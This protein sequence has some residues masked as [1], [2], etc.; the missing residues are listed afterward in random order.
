MFE[1]IYP[2]IALAYGTFGIIFGVAL[3]WKTQKRIDRTKTAIEVQVANAVTDIKAQVTESLDFDVPEFDMTPLMARLD[4]LET[5]LPDMVGTH[6][7]MA[8]KGIQATEGKQIAAYVESLGIEGI[9]EEQ[10]AMAVERLTLKQKAA[11]E[12][13]TMKIPKKTRQDHPLSTQLFEH[14]RGTI[15]QYIIESDEMSGG[16]VH[17]EGGP[18]RSGTFRPGYQP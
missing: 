14:S 3:W 7:S 2:F 17:I 18:A 1:A 11:Y 6:I 4:S 10:K 13:M 16:N 12:L 5:G 8:I 15:A 9:T